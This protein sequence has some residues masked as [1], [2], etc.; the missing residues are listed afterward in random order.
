MTRTGFWIR[1]ALSLG[2][3]LLDFTVGRA[4][5]AVPWEEGVGA[6]LATLLW[7][8]V[9]I[10]YLLELIDVTEQFDAFIPTATLIGLWVGWRRGLIFGRAPKTQA[11]EI[12]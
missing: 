10:A 1:M 6:G 4:L 11:G 2:L 7:G 5:F 3:D 12:R 9:G 8:P